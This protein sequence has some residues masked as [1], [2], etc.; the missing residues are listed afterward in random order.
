MPAGFDPYDLPV[1][2]DWPTCTADDGDGCPRCAQTA[3]RVEGY[4]DALEGQW[5]AGDEV[6]P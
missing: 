2:D 6:L 4:H 1:C 5:D 3:A